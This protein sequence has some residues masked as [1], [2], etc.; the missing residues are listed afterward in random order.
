MEKIFISNSLSDSWTAFSRIKESI[1]NISDGST[2]VFEKGIYNVSNQKGNE[3]FDSLMNGKISATDY[4]AWRDNKNIFV[5]VSCKKDITIDGNGAEI[6]FSGLVNAFDFSNCE[7]LTV[8]NISIDWSRPLFSVGTIISSDKDGIIAEVDPEYP[9]AGGEPV[10][11]YQDFDPVLKRPGGHCIFE[12]A[13]NVKLL[14]SGNVLLRGPEAET[15]PVGNKIIFRHIYSYSSVFHLFNCKNVRFENVR[16]SA[17]AGMGVIAHGCSDLSFFELT[18]APSNERLMSVNCD[19]THFIAC[20][21]KIRFKNC[22]FEAM[23]DDATNVHGFY[24]RTIKTL[25]PGVILTSLDVTTQD[26]EVEAPRAGDTVE[27]AH[28]ETLMPY[29][30]HKRRTV[31][32]VEQLE[33]Q[34]FKIAFTAPLPDG[35]KPGDMVT[36]LAKMAALDFESC[37]VKNIRGRA[38]LIQTRNASVKDCTFIG[39][40]GEGVHI[41]TAVGWAES[42]AVEN[43]IIEGNEFIDCGYGYTKYCDAVAVVIGTECERKLI[44]VH[45]DIRI[46][47]NTIVGERTGIFAECCENIALSGNSFSSGS[48]E[49]IL[50]YVKNA[51]ITDCGDISIKLGENTSE[52]VA[53]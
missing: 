16:I 42:S 15:F 52:I 5:G 20:D 24:L 30:H 12:N 17:G 11:S 35:F 40:T 21:G 29:E 38:V 19:A 27:F 7:N 13:E 43:V 2:V 4:G 23:G 49:I 9:I 25:S 44:G 37:T 48:S 32:S 47:N 18:V 26:F 14:E 8:K 39:C 31:L 50:D 10:V 1:S 41:N 33:K 34:Q 45:N 46:I 36:N 51:K 6:V 28:A 3:L 22:C 53:E